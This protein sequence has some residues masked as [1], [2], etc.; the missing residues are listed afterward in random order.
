MQRRIKPIAIATLALLLQACITNRPPAVQSAPHTAYFWLPLL[1]IADRDTARTREQFDAA[2]IR[3][4]SVR[5]G[6]GLALSISTDAQRQGDGSLGLGSYAGGYAYV[7]PRRARHGMVVVDAYDP[8][9]LRQVWSVVI[10]RSMLL[11]DAALHASLDA[12]L[13]DSQ[14]TEVAARRSRELPDPL[15]TSVRARSQANRDAL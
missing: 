3:R 5:G 11:R 13:R 1:G 7:T 14:V 6:G 4:G 9:T 2:L 8:I 10:P 15:Q 12:V